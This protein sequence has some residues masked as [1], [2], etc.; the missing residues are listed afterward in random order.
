[1]RKLTLKKVLKTYDVEAAK[2]MN[3]KKVLKPPLK[4]AG[5]ISLRADA[6][7]STKIIYNCIN[8]VNKNYQNG[9]R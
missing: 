4:T 5:P 6:A 3:A 8:I 1:M 7:R 2:S 9:I